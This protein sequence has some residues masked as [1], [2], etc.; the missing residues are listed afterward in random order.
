MNNYQI[1]PYDQQQMGWMVGMGG[2]PTPPYR[3]QFN[4]GYPP[5]KRP[6]FPSKQAIMEHIRDNVFRDVPAGV[7]VVVNLIERD[8]DRDYI[9]HFCCLPYFEHRLQKNF[10]R[11]NIPGWG[12]YNVD[13]YAHRGY[14]Q[15][16]GF[17]NTLTIVDSTIPTRDTASG[18]STFM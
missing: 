2:S 12:S 5:Q 6:P 9:P 1:T 7:P 17:C 10:I 3:Q 14:D 16:F 4:Q 18:Y 13:F 8:W 11:I 15:V